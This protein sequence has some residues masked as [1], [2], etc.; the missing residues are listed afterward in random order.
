MAEDEKGDVI[1]KLL[2][3]YSIKIQKAGCSKHPAF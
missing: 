1:S 2:I 3:H